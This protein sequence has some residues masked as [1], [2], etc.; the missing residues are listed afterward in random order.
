VFFP[1]DCAAYGH[2]LSLTQKERDAMAFN[3]KAKICKAKTKDKKPCSNPS[4]RGYDYCYQHKPVERDPWRHGLGALQLT[5][6]Y[7]KQSFDYVLDAIE[8]DFELNN[9]SDRMQSQMAAYY[10]VKWMEA[11]KEGI[12]ENASFYDGLIRKNLKCL[13]AT[14]ENR[15]GLEIKVSTP[16]E[17]A[18]QL[19]SEH[20]I[21]S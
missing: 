4:V 5:D 2:E 6:P 13:K 10:F 7:Q 20:N 14:R 16:A 21:K 3:D 8:K 1:Y 18:A 11:V 12:I 9:S 15:E 19:L 17:W